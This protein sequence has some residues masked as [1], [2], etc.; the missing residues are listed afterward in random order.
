MKY[1]LATALGFLLGCALVL[2]GLH[3]NPFTTNSEAISSANA[4]VFT[5]RSPFIEGLAVTHSGQSRLP[6]VPKEIPDLWESTI[7]D[8]ILTVIVLRDDEDVPVGIASRIS[9]FSDRTE[10]LVRGV[11]VDDDLLVTIPGEGSLFIDADSNLWPFLKETLIPVWYLY[12]PWQGPKIY[13]P[14]A[15]PAASGVAIVAGATG[16]FAAREGT[17]FESYQVSSFSATTGPGSMDARLFLN[18]PRNSTSLVAE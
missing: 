12:R 15:G 4:R 18:L 2:V 16:S 8:S 10:L 6:L 13:H 1:V 7:S 17:A 11:L 9:Q 14:T 3:Y 5:Y